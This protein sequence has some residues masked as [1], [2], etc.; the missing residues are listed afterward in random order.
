MTD[1]ELKKGILKELNEFRWQLQRDDIP[2]LTT[3]TL[4]VLQG[5]VA[6]A[7]LQLIHVW[8]RGK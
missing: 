2:A 1:E 5:A 8:L 4:V 6:D 3:D 7:I